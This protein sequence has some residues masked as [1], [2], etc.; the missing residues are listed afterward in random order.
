[1]IST[2]NPSFS[3]PVVPP[4]V[5][6]WPSRNGRPRVNLSQLQVQLFDLDAQYRTSLE[7]TTTADTET[8]LERGPPTKSAR[9]GGR[10]QVR[11]TDEAPTI[12]VYEQ[13]D[14][15]E[16]EITT[17]HSSLRRRNVDLSPVKN[18]KYEGMFVIYCHPAS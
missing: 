14:F 3:L 8:P 2:E 15:L 12:I 13:V 5:S 18:D 10:K 4:A 7:F 6:E 1:M 17:N 16:G 11:F 9:K